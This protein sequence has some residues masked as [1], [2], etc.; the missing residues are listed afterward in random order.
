MA[1]P[2]PPS[3]TTTTLTEPA[4]TLEARAVCDQPAIE[5]TI[6]APA[7]HDIELW[8]LDRHSD[9]QKLFS[10]FGTA[11]AEPTKWT[12][13]IPN[14]ITTARVVAF[15]RTVGQGEKLIDID[16]IRACATPTGS[17][18]LPFTGLSTSELLTA[19]AG[20]VAGGAF[21]LR[22]VSRRRR[23]RNRIRRLTAAT[24]TS[25]DWTLIT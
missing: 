16:M 25:S 17:P 4:Y 23:H 20:L 7:G 8:V 15:D 24:R 5:A 1:Q 10:D 3:E 6:T 11:R 18:K 14:H 9:Q 19:G 13:P 22:A 2:P 21:L 12:V